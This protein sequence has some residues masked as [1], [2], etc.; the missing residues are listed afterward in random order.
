MSDTTIYLCGPIAGCTDDQC[1]DW[2]DHATEL[3]TNRVTGTMLYGRRTCTVLNPMD[4]D[5]RGRCD[6]LFQEVVQ[7]DKRDIRNSDCML[8]NWTQP[9]VGTSMEI[10]YA[11]ENNVV[12]V[13]VLPEDLPKYDISPWLLYHCTKITNDLEEAI[14]WIRKNV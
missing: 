9:S 1:K 6:D 14:D 11:W 3:L 12:N 10:L 5:Y 13:L 7:L 8:I 4:R 2:R